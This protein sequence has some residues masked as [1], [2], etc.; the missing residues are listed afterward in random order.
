MTMDAQK[1]R[2]H[3]L[4]R[5]RELT[6]QLDS[7]DASASRVPTTAAGTDVYFPVSGNQMLIHLAQ[8]MPRSSARYVVRG[9]DPR[10]SAVT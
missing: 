10:A 4:E 1:A 5:E 2:V 9:P 3:L 6:Q 8:K 7:A